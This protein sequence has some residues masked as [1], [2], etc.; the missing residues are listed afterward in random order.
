M[1]RPT[2]IP[3]VCYSPAR[4]SRD[5]QAEPPAR[6]Q[7]VS[8]NLRTLY[9]STPHTGVLQWTDALAQTYAA[10]AGMRTSMPMLLTNTPMSEIAR[11][12]DS[13]FE[14]LAQA[15]DLYPDLAHGIAASWEKA[16]ASRLP[17]E[18]L[19]DV[20]RRVVSAPNLRDIRRSIERSSAREG[21]RAGQCVPPAGEHWWRCVC[22]AFHWFRMA[23]T[24]HCTNAPESHYEHRARELAL[25]VSAA[26]PEYHFRRHGVSGVLTGL[27]Y[28]F[29]CVNRTAHDMLHAAPLHVEQARL[30][31]RDRHFAEA[32]AREQWRQS[33]GMRASAPFRRTHASDHRAT[34]NVG[35]SYIETV[36]QALD[37]CLS[38]AIGVGDWIGTFGLPADPWQFP[39]AAGASQ[40]NPSSPVF[41]PASTLTATA[42]RQPAR[43]RHLV[44][45]TTADPAPWRASPTARR[46]TALA[47]SHA[48]RAENRQ[49]VHD[50]VA[51]MLNIRH[52]VRTTLIER[53]GA[54]YAGAD[55]DTL[56][57]NR[58]RFFGNPSHLRLPTGAIA[59]RGLVESS[60]LTD[61]GMR[62][63]ARTDRVQESS[64]E[65]GIYLR[66]ATATAYALPDDEFAGMTVDDF[67][68]AIE[69]GRT[70]WRQAILQLETPDA[71]AA[72]V[73]TLYERALRTL[74]QDATILYSAGRLSPDG[75]VLAQIVAIAPDGASRRASFDSFLADVKGMAVAVQVPG[76]AGH[77]RPAGMFAVSEHPVSITRNPLRV[78]LAIPGSELP[79]REYSS[80][81]SL[82][83]DLARGSASSLYLEVVQRL[84]IEVQRSCLSGQ[85]CR[86]TFPES[87]D[88]LLRM[89]LQTT[90]AVILHDAEV[91][92]SALLDS[93]RHD[94]WIA[95]LAGASPD[96]LDRGIESASP[97]DT[98]F[99]RGFPPDALPHR[100]RLSIDGETTEKINRLAR[101]RVEISAALPDLAHRAND[102]VR[103]LVANMT[104]VHVSPSS[105]Y[106][107]VFRE[108]THL[109]PDTRQPDGEPRTTLETTS[110]LQWMASLAEG[111]R[112]K[113]LPDGTYAI[114]SLDRNAALA[115][116]LDIPGLTPAKLLQAIDVASFVARQSEDFRAFWK[117]RGQDIATTLKAA[118]IIESY[119]KSH[120]G[121]LSAEAAEIARL[122]CG[123]RSLESLDLDVSQISTAP[124][125][126]VQ[127]AWLSVGSAISDIQV[128]TD[129]RSGWRLVYAPR[130]LD[131]VLI[132][133]DTPSRFNAWLMNQIRNPATRARLARAFTRAAREN[134]EANGIANIVRQY[135]APELSQLTTSLVPFTGDP[136]Q[137][138]VHV[139]ETRSADEIRHN[140][141]EAPT[142]ALSRLMDWLTT[143]N[144]LC[145]IGTLV[146]LPIPGLTELN[147]AVSVT[148][149]VLGAASLSLDGPD[150]RSTA[151]NALI[152]GTAGIPLGWYRS[153][154]ASLGT[155]LAPFV[156]TTPLR[157]LQRLMPNL[158]RT[159]TGMVVRSGDQF[160]NV[161]YFPERGAWQMVDPMHPAD[162]GPSITQTSD[163]EWVLAASSA[164][165]TSQGSVIDSVF[166]E[167]VNRKF[168]DVEFRS[169]LTA[170]L[171]AASP[172]HRAAF[173]AGKQE[174]ERS[175][176]HRANTSRPS[177]LLKLDFIDPA[178][179]N[180]TL[181]GILS[182][183][184]E[185]AERAEAALRASMNAR[186]VAS[187]IESAGGKFTV[188][189]QS[190]YLSRNGNGATGFCLPLVRLMA[191]AQQQA[192]DAAC[193][194]MIER[195]A[196]WPDTEEAVS[197]R[198]ALV[199]LHSSQAATA[200]ETNVGFLDL[201]TLGQTICDGPRHATYLVCTRVHSLSV[202]VVPGQALFFDPNFGMAEF[203]TPGEAIEALKRHL[204]RHDLGRRYGAFRAA[205]TLLFS[206]K[207]LDM[208]A[209]SNVDVGGRRAVDVVLA[210]RA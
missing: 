1:T 107:H 206:V 159:S 109:A 141:R 128:F 34:P 162:I 173:A 183:R 19:C 156:A 99:P 64:L 153:A 62:F 172:E 116:E 59:R 14:L 44:E 77:Y 185:E 90:I 42:R 43:H 45:V 187:E 144:V 195:A 10:C 163:Y 122:V 129:A 91:G 180:P 28:A 65:Y 55:P 16:L 202:I 197:L 94:R 176:L 74:E 105:L 21:A 2:A 161:D 186:V 108:P 209:L 81:E 87:E 53:F 126:T 114:F 160:F 145:G 7:N 22:N 158:Y 67:A 51:P 58:F 170:Q 127:M 118:F 166:H 142:M 93:A 15:L 131:D 97:G 200:A 86:V 148:D 203:T 133:F 147:T 26:P 92:G 149:I 198:S 135:V 4:C 49:R 41:A 98:G 124:P 207:R 121:R 48:E 140:T 57:F 38:A 68:D 119:V 164:G 80:M 106:L 71:D 20:A 17:F 63:F 9:A 6:A 83:R 61:A 60:H 50:T 102:Y 89:S 66:N 150:S 123:S 12:L 178:N 181:L 165:D 132:A 210:A 151:W 196:L 174:A 46:V 25:A 75:L 194:R 37:A 79:L 36:R 32:H 110:L 23:G 117:R 35:E 69:V 177:E 134:A 73:S 76:Y 138:Y 72:E 192:R 13:E 5:S 155:Q 130:L 208:D 113:T 171:H 182:R 189:T 47:Q 103:E 31:A 137:A 188:F 115:R 84:P 193:L 29:A 175:P 52:F 136:F 18:S 39:V 179:T 111:T 70:Q 169:K 112:D 96:E 204:T 8:E 168:I 201:D 190:T 88:D 154:F 95:W 143:I 152:I 125:E 157:Q 120:D 40:A 100:E 199:K 11:F 146:H 167:N 101:L 27:L 139:F 82:Q 24:G 30:F 205:G 56:Y 184:I 54:T 33:A 104:G 85:A 3:P 78:L 191:I